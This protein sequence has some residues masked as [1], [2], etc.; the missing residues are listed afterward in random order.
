MFV[1]RCGVTTVVAVLLYEYRAP[2]FIPD[3]M[4]I[5]VILLTY[6]GQLWHTEK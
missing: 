1:L 2:V 4:D 6:T 5:E 3:I